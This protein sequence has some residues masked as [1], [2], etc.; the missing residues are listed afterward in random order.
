MQIEENARNAMADAFGGLFGAGSVLRFR[1]SN[2]SEVATLTLDDDA[3]QAA[4]SGTIVAN[5][6]APDP[7]AA[8][9]TIDHAVLMDDSSAVQATLTVGTSSGDIIITTLTIASGSTV[10][11]TSLQFTMP[12]S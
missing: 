9:G 5:A 11:M 2:E 6:I 1:A 12:A 4:S 8:G 3:F 7:D 10:S